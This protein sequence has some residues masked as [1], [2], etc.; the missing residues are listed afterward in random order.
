MLAIIF[1][2]TVNTVA[3]H[4]RCRILIGAHLVFNAFLKVASS[5]KKPPSSKKPPKTKFVTVR[6]R[7][8]KEELA[9]ELEYDEC[10]RDDA[11]KQISKQFIR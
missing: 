6:E 7:R 8:H 9:R 5:F 1:I 10:R 3:T 2:S 4:T 11:E